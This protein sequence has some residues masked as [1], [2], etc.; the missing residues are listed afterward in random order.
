LQCR[1]VT[2]ADYSKGRGAFI[3]RATQINCNDEEA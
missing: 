2:G 3:F 1:C